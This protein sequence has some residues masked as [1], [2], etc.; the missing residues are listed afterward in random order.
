MNNNRV[1][2]IRARMNDRRAQVVNAQQRIFQLNQ[3]KATID[4]QIT[5]QQN[6]VDQAI[7]QDATDRAELAS[8]DYS[9][10][11]KQ[12]KILFLLGERFLVLPFLF[13][14]DMPVEITSV[15]ILNRM[16]ND[17]LRY[18]LRGYG[19]SEEGSQPELRK[20]LIMHFGIPRDHA[21]RLYEY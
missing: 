7:N 14:Q 4:N 21:E 16:N 19:L 11:K 17:L 12:N 1:V 3:E 9:S 5:E 2:Q 10:L 20:R 8:L 6:I 13:E 18:Y 15:E